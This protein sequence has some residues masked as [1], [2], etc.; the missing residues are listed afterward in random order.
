MWPFLRYPICPF[1]WLGESSSINR[2]V[3]RKSGKRCRLLTAFHLFL[4]V[5]KGKQTEETLDNE[6]I[7]IIPGNYLLFIVTGTMDFRAS[8]AKARR[9]GRQQSGRRKRWKKRCKTRA[10]F[11]IY[12]FCL[13]VMAWRRR[14]ENSDSRIDLA[15]PGCVPAINQRHFRPGTAFSKVD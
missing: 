9:N 15:P 7:L 13:A 4:H 12:L 1:P 2:V 10:L 8:L 3:E 11:E 14:R 5:I 6:C